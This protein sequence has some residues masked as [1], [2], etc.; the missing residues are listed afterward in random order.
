[1]TAPREL[2]TFG[3]AISEYGFNAAAKLISATPRG[4]AERHEASVLRCARC[5]REHDGSVVDERGLSEFCSESC[6]L[7]ERA[8]RGMGR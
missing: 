7:S 1:M 6:L 4:D 2:M 3:E 8:E 5:D